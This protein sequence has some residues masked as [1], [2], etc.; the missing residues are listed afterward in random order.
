[1]L[2]AFVLIVFL[3]ILLSHQPY[4][5]RISYEPVGSGDSGIRVFTLK[6]L[7]PVGEIDISTENCKT[8]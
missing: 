8:V 1:M 3:V 6:E 4:L 7:R 2:L 5:I